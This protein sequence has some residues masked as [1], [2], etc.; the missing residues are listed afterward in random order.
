MATLS[1][2]LGLKLWTNADAFS[3]AEVTE[4]FAL[5]DLA[6]GTLIV[7]SG[8][9]PSDWG[10]DETGRFIWDT[11]VELLFQWDGTDFQRVHPLGNLAHVRR[12][13]DF[14]TTNTAAQ[15]AVTASPSV[16]VGDRELQIRGTWSLAE[17]TGG[18][19]AVSLWRGSN[20]L[21]E[22]QVPGTTSP[23]APYKAGTGGVIE[24]TDVPFPSGSGV[25]TYTLRFRV[26]TGYAGTA[27]LRAG[28]DH[29]AEL[30]VTET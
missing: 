2:H 8:S 13:S 28:A 15:I 21:H 25:A 5:L 11:D 30:T 24:I 18:L 22:V 29:P 14:S 12:T 27:T 6:P 20:Q 4:N 17:S 23:D 26:V 10:A 1:T 9:H 19:M 16:P 7:D 3:T